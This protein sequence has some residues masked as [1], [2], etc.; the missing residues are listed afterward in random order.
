MNNTEL[1][2][3]QPSEYLKNGFYDNGE[4]L[5]GLN[6]YYS[7]GMAYRLREEK[8]DVD[9]LQNV[10]DQLQSIID[11][12]D[13]SIDE[14]PNL[15]LDSQSLQALDEVVKKS[16]SPIISEIFVAARPWIKDWRTLAALVIHLHRIVGQYSLISTLP[17]EE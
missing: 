15:P 6:G 9:Q 14:N 13:G 17:K 7:L 2:T 3:V 10:T 12:K 4:I 16:P 1:L 11:R 8:A 5:E